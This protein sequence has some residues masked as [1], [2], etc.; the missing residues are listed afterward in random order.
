MSIACLPLAVL[1]CQFHVVSL[2]SAGLICAA[3]ILVFGVFQVDFALGLIPDV[4]CPIFRRCPC[5]V[6]ERPAVSLSSCVSSFADLLSGCPLWKSMCKSHLRP[7]M[8]VTFSKRGVRHL[9]QAQR[10]WQSGSSLVT[11]ILG[12]LH[13]PGAQW[14]CSP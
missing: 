11:F 1:T 10:T 12:P 7:Q 9:F 2:T 6:S 14:W 8:T 13:H 5:L 3:L 4:F